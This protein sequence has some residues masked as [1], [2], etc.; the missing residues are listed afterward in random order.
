MSGHASHS[1]SAFN[2]VTGI[3][4]V[5]ST[6]LRC[7]AVVGTV[8]G[9]A[10]CTLPTQQ[11]KTSN[12]P[13]MSSK[14]L[15]TCCFI[16]VKPPRF[17]TGSDDAVYCIIT[18]NSNCPVGSGFAISPELIVTA[19]HVRFADATVLAVSAVKSLLKQGDKIIEP[20]LKI[21]LEV[22]VCNAAEDWCV[23]K[24]KDGSLFA[25]VAPLANEDE[26]P[27]E[28]AQHHEKITI[29]YFCGGLFR[30]KLTVRHKVADMDQFQRCDDIEADNEAELQ[31]KGGFTTS[32]MCGAPYFYN[33]KV[34]AFHV[35]SDSE[36]LQYDEMNT[37]KYTEHFSVGRV[38]CRLPLFMLALGTQFDTAKYNLA[39][40]QLAVIRAVGR[41]TSTTSTTNTASSTSSTSTTRAI[42]Q[43]KVT[44]KVEAVGCCATVTGSAATVTHKKKKAAKCVRS[45]KRGGKISRTIT[46]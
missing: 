38:L 29:R 15:L 46:G 26:L 10:V 11:C 12:I 43:E 35:Q 44:Q 34:I 31:V 2:P 24:R 17:S 20:E 1:W 42:V 4:L 25:H 37:K 33:D 21:E 9:V 8:K 41:T 28:C 23:L 13:F 36:S 7:G 6:C 45:D 39:L 16:T 27:D 3:E 30:E 32:G 18:T 40:S 14:A 19:N 5:A 22:V